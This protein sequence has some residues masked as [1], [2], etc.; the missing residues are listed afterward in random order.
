M[1][2][3]KKIFNKFRFIKIYIFKDNKSYFYNL[4]NKKIINKD[5]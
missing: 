3:I 1:I 2:K 5:N 4:K